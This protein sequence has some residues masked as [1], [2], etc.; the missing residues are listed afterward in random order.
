MSKPAATPR[1]PLSSPP[2]PLAGYYQDATGGRFWV[3]S[4]ASFALYRLGPDS[5]PLDPESPL[6]DD[7]AKFAAAVAFG[8][9]ARINH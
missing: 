3:P 8:T 6:Q 1:K 7:P 9:F 4:R 2:H 5:Q